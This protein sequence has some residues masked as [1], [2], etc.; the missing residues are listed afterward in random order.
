MWHAISRQLTGQLA[1][2][3]RSHAVGHH[4]E[5]PARLE[6]FRSV[7]RQQRMRILIRRAA[8]ADIGKRCRF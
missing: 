5:V 1:G 2:S 8:H 6:Q 4:E 3:V 7:G